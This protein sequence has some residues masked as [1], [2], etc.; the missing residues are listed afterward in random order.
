[1]RKSGLPGH[2]GIIMDGNGRWA[3]IRG[4]P[5]VEGHRQGVHRSKDII[6]AA[7]KAGLEALTL[8]A[9]SIEN[10]RRPDLEVYTLM[11]LLDMYLRTEIDFLFENGITFRVIGNRQRLSVGLN[12]LIEKAEELT[13]QNR[14]MYLN[15][16]IS[17]GGRDEIL[18]TIRKMA[19][20]GYD[21]T[22]IEEHDFA[23][24]LDTGQ[25]DTVDLIIRTGGE[26]RLSNF[27][28]W[29]AAYA[30]FYYT[31]TLWPDFT[32]EEFYMA[33]HNYN[34]RE[35]RFGTSAEKVSF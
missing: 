3:N 16:A 32:R 24:N 19:L 5:R 28:I 34:Q 13:S 22:K 21:M 15:L 11:Q 7:N 8:Y 29:Q 9:F 18:R 35:R 23:V 12:F 4:L 10:W 25:R 6:D 31:D 14:G 27:L 1:M 26:Q 30:E 2:V 20:E 33:I 17:Y